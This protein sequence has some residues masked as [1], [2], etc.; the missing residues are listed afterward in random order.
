MAKHEFMTAKAAANRMK[1]KGLQKL[2]WYC[3][4]CEKQC[5]DQNGFKCHCASES[6]QRQMTIF[7]ENPERYVDQFSQEFEQVFL[8]ILSRRYGTKKVHANQVYQELIADRQHLHMNATKWNS[9]SD[10]AMYLGR[11]G[12]CR[13]ED[14]ERGWVIEW[15]DTSPEALARKAAITKKERQEM[16]DEQ[17]EQ[18]LLQE[19]ITRAQKSQQAGA[20]QAQETGIPES[21]AATDLKRENTNQPIKLTWKIAPGKESL[22]QPGLLKSSK[23]QFKPKPNL[24]KPNPFKAALASQQGSLSKK[25]PTSSGAGEDQVQASRPL[26]A[27][28][29]AVE[30]V[31]RQ[32]LLRKGLHNTASGRSYSGTTQRR[33]RSPNSSYRSGASSGLR[34]D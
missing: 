23:L 28:P 5:R 8:S 10:F 30:G 15:I 29:T 32:E 1:A 27:K 7:A 17:R 4:M 24:A 9:L 34:R 21:S 2:R 31:M 11:E 12:K 25:T 33:S 6:H 22:G 13:V 3:Q 16:D 19:Q 26:P 20:H 18:M 14:S